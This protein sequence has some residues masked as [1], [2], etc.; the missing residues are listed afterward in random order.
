VLRPGG[1]VALLDSDWAT[2]ITHPGDPEVLERY[3]AFQLTQWPNPFSGRRLRGQLVA[4]SL[5]VDPD[6]GSSALVLPDEALREGGM[7][8]MSGPAA[9]EAGA[10]T[11]DELDALVS[12][13]S[14]AAACGEAFVSVTMFGVLGRRPG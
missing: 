2:G 11:Q 13:V 12:G 9:V 6:V 8:G 5:V 1:R 10:V 4:A 7:I 14:A 3:R